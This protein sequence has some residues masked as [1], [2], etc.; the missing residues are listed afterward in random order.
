MSLR[1]VLGFSECYVKWSHFKGIRWA[2]CSTTSSIL[3]SISILDVLCSGGIIIGH[4]GPTY[5]CLEGLKF[6]PGASHLGSPRLLT[7]VG[8]SHPTNIFAFKFWTKNYYCINHCKLTDVSHQCE[9]SMW[10]I[11][12]R[13]YNNKSCRLE[14]AVLF[15]Q[16]ENYHSTSSFPSLGSAR[17]VALLAIF[18]LA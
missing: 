3:T 12:L 5:M 17:M 15:I 10:V 8:C 11:C 6:Y 13:L 16:Q 9:S 7:Q 18:W 4:F 1:T 14:A 2:P